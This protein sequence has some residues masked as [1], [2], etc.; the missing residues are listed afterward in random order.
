[1]WSRVCS[2]APEYSHSS[3]LSDFRASGSSAGSSASRRAF[4][5]ITGKGGHS[6][7]SSPM[8]LPQPKLKEIVGEGRGPS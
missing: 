5:L 7:S 2:H 6:N 8:S 1:M 3:S 4:L